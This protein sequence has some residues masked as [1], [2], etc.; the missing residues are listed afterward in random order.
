MHLLSAPEPPQWQGSF[1]ESSSQEEQ[2][3]GEPPHFPSASSSGHTKYEPFR[4]T[5]KL[6]LSCE[7]LLVFSLLV[8]GPPPDAFVESPPQPAIP[9]I[10]TK[11]TTASSRDRILVSPSFS[12]ASPTN[13]ASATHSGARHRP[14]VRRRCDALRRGTSTAGTP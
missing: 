12:V 11:T 9:T 1:E 14:T 13:D 4:H 6:E 5:V 3:E 7:L 8:S 2:S 10:A